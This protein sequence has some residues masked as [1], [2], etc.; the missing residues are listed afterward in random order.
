MVC[1][2][3]DIDADRDKYDD[4]NDDDSDDLNGDKGARGIAKPAKQ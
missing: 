4:D 2:I 3:G 1:H